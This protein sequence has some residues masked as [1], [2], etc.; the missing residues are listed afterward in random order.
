MSDEFETLEVD[1]P[2]E[3]QHQ[4]VRLYVETRMT[5]PS[6]ATFKE[7]LATESV[8]TALYYAVINEI[9]ISALSAHIKTQDGANN[10]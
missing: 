7:S 4:M 1:I 8:E 10:E 2:E 6:I 9:A 3:Q 5:P